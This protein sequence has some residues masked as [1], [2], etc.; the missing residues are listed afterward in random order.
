MLTHASDVENDRYSLPTPE[1]FFNYRVVV[2]SCMDAA[3][4]VV[5]Q[6]TNIGVMDQKQFKPAHPLRTSTQRLK[7]HWTHLIIDEVSYNTACDID[8]DS[9][10]S[11]AA[12]GS[13]PELLIPISV[14]VT[15]PRIHNDNQ[16]FIIPQLVLCGDPMQRKPHRMSLVTVRTNSLFP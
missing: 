2:T 4:L 10:F 14:V 9:G 1:K 16:N 8:A 15:D 13:E 12:Q 3:H 5:A 6:F 11:Q 7:P